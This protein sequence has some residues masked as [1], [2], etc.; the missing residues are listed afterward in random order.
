MHY[1]LETYTRRDVAFVMSKIYGG[2]G[3]D[4]GG[5]TISIKHPEIEEW[6]AEQ[7]AKEKESDV[8]EN[9]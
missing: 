7:Y 1:A 5:T 4:K 8:R 3:S 6:V 2:K 9:E